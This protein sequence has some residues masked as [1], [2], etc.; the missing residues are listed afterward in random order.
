MRRFAGVG[1]ALLFLPTAGWAQ[2]YSR[3][4]T[5]PIIP[6]QETLERQNL[7]LAWRAYLPVDGRR[8]GLFSVHPLGDQILVQ[9]RSGAVIAIDAEKGTTQWR[10]RVGLPY[11]VTQDLGYNKRSVFVVNGL[12]LYALD[13]KS[14]RMQW[15]FDLPTAMRATPVADEQRLYLC[16]VND[17]LYIYDIP[18][19][20]KPFMGPLAPPQKKE[21]NETRL[22]GQEFRSF[23][24][25]SRTIQGA[26]VIGSEAGVRDDHVTKGLQPK[27]VAFLDT[28]TRVDD[29]PILTPDLIT[30]PGG[31]TRSPRQVAGVADRAIVS[32][33]VTK[34]A[35]YTYFYMTSRKEPRQFTPYRIDAPLTAP[36]AQ[37][38]DTVY[39]AERDA[40]FYA[41]DLA[42]GRNLWRIPLTR[43]LV[44]RK[45]EVTDDDLYLSPER[46]GMYRLQ[47][48]TGDTL[49]NQPN[50]EQF[51]SHTKKRVF[52]TDR[53]GRLLILDRNRGTLLGLL[54]TR[55][56]VVPISNDTTDRIYLGANDGLLICLRDRELVAP[57]VNKTVMEKKPEAVKPG[58]K[59]PDRGDAGAKEKKDDKDMKKDEAEMKK[60]DKDMKKDEKEK[61]KE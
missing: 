40:N 60:D 5:Q 29:P 51:L 48:R 46:G 50:A 17:R 39:L 3:L 37:L 43:A 59:P 8:D 6:T 44:V 41:L 11:L 23:S 12:R 25:Y 35:G 55:D 21:E 24:V 42:S 7:K 30:L 26:G 2:G 20:G 13:R 61:E 47:R 15:E 27:L 54:D 56:F 38:G 22:P 31:A 16:M 33:S 57:Q 10:A 4:Y 19:E 18:P 34:A 9:L 32:D 49:W 52:A 28:H 58:D 45:P 14:G 1:L 36:V 53:Q